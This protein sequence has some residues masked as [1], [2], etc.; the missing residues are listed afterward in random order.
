MTKQ[1]QAAQ[2]IKHYKNTY[3]GCMLDETTQE[4]AGDQHQ[5]IRQEIILQ[6]T[7][8]KLPLKQCTTGTL[9]RIFKKEFN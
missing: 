7:G 6:L 8:E 9:A 5:V 3:S 4:L 1:T 2:L